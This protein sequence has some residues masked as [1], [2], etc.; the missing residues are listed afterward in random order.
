MQA[1]GDALPVNV[2][3]GQA[4][5]DGATFCIVNGGARPSQGAH[6][7]VRAGGDDAST[8]DSQGS[9]LWLRRI[10]GVDA[11]VE[12]NAVHHGLVDCELWIANC[13]LRIAN[14]GL[15]SLST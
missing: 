12:Q 7:V 13:G 8:P 10:E 6:G 15:W 11:S 14:C 5:E 2:G 4:G 3:V 1:A 9:G